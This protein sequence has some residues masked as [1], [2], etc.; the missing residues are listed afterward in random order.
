MTPLTTC[1]CAMRMTW[2][3]APADPAVLRVAV[4]VAPMVSV[5]SC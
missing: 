5:Q 3:D 1:V 2:L 4:A